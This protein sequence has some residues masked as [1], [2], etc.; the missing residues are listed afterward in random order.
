MR[1]KAIVLSLML[2]ASTSVLAGQ[3]LLEG[4]AKQVVQDK[5]TEV[6]PNAIEKAGAANQTLDKAK[7]LKGAA[8]KAPD[9][10]QDQA[11]EA[12]KEKAKKAMPEEAKKAGETLKT[13]KDTAENL[14]G[15]ADSAPKSTKAIKNKAKGKAAEKAFDLVH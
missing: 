12:V 8:E 3:S 2:V 4:V 1:N 14:K 6:A 9:T 15:Q 7:A 11:T 5:A 13:G 10:L